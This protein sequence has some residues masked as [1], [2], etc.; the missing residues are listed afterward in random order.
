MLL[1][2]EKRYLLLQYISP[3][4]KSLLQSLVTYSVCVIT[5]E[6]QSV[7]LV[8]CLNIL[9]KYEFLSLCLFGLDIRYQT[10]LLS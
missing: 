3:E 4:L 7:R 10:K 9:P 6:N 8:T 1:L 5:G 2:P